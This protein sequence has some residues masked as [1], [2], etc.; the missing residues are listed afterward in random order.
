VKGAIK[1]VVVVLAAVSAPSTFT[2]L[3]IGD[4]GEDLSVPEAILSQWMEAASKGDTQKVQALLGKGADVNAKD[5]M[6]ETA[7]IIAA[8]YGHTDTV[9]VLL[10]EGADVNAKNNKG[11]TALR[12]AKLAGHNEIV[13]MLEEWVPPLLVNTP[14]R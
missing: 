7:L 10:E 11:I 3:S 5:D 4:I 12:A 6:G 14:K 8:Y 1:L 2:T 13:L 9:K